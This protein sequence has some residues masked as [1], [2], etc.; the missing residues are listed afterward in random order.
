MQVKYVSRH[1]INSNYNQSTSQHE[2]MWGQFI[3]CNKTFEPKILIS[4]M[5]IEI[6][7]LL[8][9][10]SNFLKQLGSDVF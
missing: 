9:R 2:S 6:F 8:K 3:K 7:H 1:K 10:V 4:C 5:F